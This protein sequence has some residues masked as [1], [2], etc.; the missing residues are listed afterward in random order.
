MTTNIYKLAA[1]LLFLAGNFYSCNKD[2]E[3]AFNRKE[4]VRNKK[5]GK[6]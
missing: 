3:L 6:T 5:N 4:F 2:P 1:V